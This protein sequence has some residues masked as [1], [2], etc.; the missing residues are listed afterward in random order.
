M[1]IINVEISGAFAVLISIV[2][3]LSLLAYAL[4]KFV[5]NPMLS[6]LVTYLPLL[7]VLIAAAILCAIIT[8]AR[9]V[10]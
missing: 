2:G 1:E 3:G 9:S 8:F 5:E 4:L 6:D 10:G 7:L